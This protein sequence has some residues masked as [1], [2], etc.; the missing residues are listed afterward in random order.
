MIREHLETS[1]ENIVEVL[2]IYL[3]PARVARLGAVDKTAIC[4]A[5]GDAR[6]EGMKY[7]SLNIA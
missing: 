7:S 2:G 3:N 4:R 6:E 5:P 1:N